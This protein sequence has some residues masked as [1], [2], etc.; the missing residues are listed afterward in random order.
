[1]RLEEPDHVLQAGDLFGAIELF[2]D[3]RLRTQTAR[4][5]T[6]IELLRLDTDVL[7]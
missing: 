5:L 6:D 4:A 1:M 3:A 2:S 7:S